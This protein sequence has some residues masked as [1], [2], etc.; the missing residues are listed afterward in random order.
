MSALESLLD[1][2][3]ENGFGGDM[4]FFYGNNS[5]VCPR[6]LRPIVMVVYSVVEWGSSRETRTS[7]P[8][9]NE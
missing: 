6:V 2:H 9:G 4:G 8:R 5:P 1:D 3:L 7:I